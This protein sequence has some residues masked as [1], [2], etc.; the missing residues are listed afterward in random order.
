MFNFFEKYSSLIGK[1]SLFALVLIISF[2]VILSILNLKFYDIDELNLFANTI[3]S[4]ASI[5]ILFWALN[6]TR[7]SNNI[8]ALQNKIMMSQ[9]IYDEYSKKIDQLNQEGDTNIFTNNEL[10]T[11]NETFAL[12]ASKITYKNFHTYASYIIFL[13]DP[14][15]VYY[16][17]YIKLPKEEKLKIEE[18]SIDQIEKIYNFTHTLYRTFEQPLYFQRDILSLYKY[19]LHSKFLMKQQKEQLFLKIN[20]VNS[21]FMTFCES[22][23]DDELIEYYD[24]MKFNMI[25]EDH[26]TYITEKSPILKN[27]KMFYNKILEQTKL[28]TELKE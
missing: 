24:L 14:Q 10:N 19:I 16:L 23:K 28:L 9:S 22:F 26:D 17:K 7:K 20:D 8:I 1:Y 21:K 5:A 15:N 2:C 27:T 25:Y 4:V 18:N 13:F 3:S 11:I 6:E 12:D